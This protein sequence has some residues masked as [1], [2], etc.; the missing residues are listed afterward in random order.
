MKKL[1]LVLAIVLGMGT[2]AFAQEISPE[3]YEEA[4][5]F[6]KGFGIFTSDTEESLLGLPDEHGFGGDV[7]ADEVPLG[8]G[9]VLLAGMGAA[10]L[11]K[12]KKND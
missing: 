5:L 7:D 1:S 2:M 8:S 11:L 12:N 9:I 4:G 6:G 3:A 10:Y